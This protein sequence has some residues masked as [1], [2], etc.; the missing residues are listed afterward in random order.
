MFFGVGAEQFK[1]Q[2]GFFQCAYAF[3]AHFNG[4]LHQ[5]FHGLF[6]QFCNVQTG[7]IGTRLLVC[8][9]GFAVLRHTAVLLFH[10]LMTA[11]FGIDLFFVGT[12]I[13]LVI[14]PLVVIAL[15]VLVIVPLV[16]IALIIVALVVLLIIALIV[17]ALVVLLIVTLIIVIILLIVAPLLLLKFRRIVSADLGGFLFFFGKD[18]RRS[19][20]RL[21]RFRGRNI[22]I[23]FAVIRQ[24]GRCLTDGRFLRGNNDLIRA[25]DFFDFLRCVLIV[26]AVQSHGA[27]FFHTFIVSGGRGGLFNGS[28]SRS[29]LFCSDSVF[30]GF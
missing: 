7:Q 3:D 28:G 25:D 27:D 30:S 11:E 17:V 23:F 12:L 15:I 5:L 2:F 14:V 16:V 29:W 24:S 26:P 13:V 21:F 18:R 8:H 6:L 22:S 1:N 20:D 19:G 10:A 4:E 9:G